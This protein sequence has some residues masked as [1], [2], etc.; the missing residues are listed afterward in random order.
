VIIYFVIAA[1]IG[2]LCRKPLIQNPDSAEIAAQRIESIETRGHDAI[3][4]LAYR[5]KYYP[6]V[7]ILTRIFAS[8]YEYYEYNDDTMDDANLTLQFK[9]SGILSAIF[10]SLAGKF[11]MV[12]RH[13]KAMLILLYHTYPLLVNG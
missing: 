8:W 4:V 10:T 6:I 7:Q 12:S 1:A 11:F 9:V 3:K 13:F 2:D 5:M